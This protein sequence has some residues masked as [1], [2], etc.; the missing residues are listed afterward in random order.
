M[1]QNNKR[2]LFLFLVIFLL[3]VASCT[4]DRTPGLPTASTPTRTDPPTVVPSPTLSP[5][6]T[7][8]ATPTPTI[9]P[10]PVPEYEP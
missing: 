2:Q 6:I 7:P 10:T 8:T 4:P 9:E 3:G 1:L 5:T